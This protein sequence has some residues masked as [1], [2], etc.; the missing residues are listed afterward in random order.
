MEAI[1]DATAKEFSREQL[2]GWWF[3]VDVSSKDVIDDYQEAG[4]SYR[5]VAARLSAKMQTLVT[6]KIMSDL[7]K[8][9]A[10]MKEL[11]K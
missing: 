1:V 3:D 9:E 6:P 10:S 8:D 4:I 7:L 2:G 5:D 11:M